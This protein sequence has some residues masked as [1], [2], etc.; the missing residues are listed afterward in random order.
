MTLLDN[1][2]AGSSTLTGR[3]YLRVSKD[4]F[5]RMRSPEQQHGEN[6][7]DAAA[8][9]IILGKPYTERDAVS[10]SRYSTK[11]RD[12][13]DQLLSDLA[14]GTFGA[15][16]LY[17]WE[18]SRGSRRVGEW[19][20]LLDLLEERGVK[21]RVKSHGRTYD[22][23][24]PRD[25]RTLLEDAVDSEYE[26]GKTSLR[27][28]RDVAAN[29][30]AG[31]PHGAAPYGYVAAHDERT[32]RLINWEPDPDRAPVIE[33][34]FERLRKGHSLK[35]IA[36][37]FAG[38]GIVNKRGRPFSPQHLRNLALKA[39][40]TGLRVHKGETVEGTWPKIVDRATWWEVQNVL[41]GVKHRTSASKPGRALHAFTGAVRCDVCGGP[42]GVTYTRGHDQY[43]CQT[44][45]CVRIAKDDVD[46]VLT[47][48]II[49]YLARPDVYAEL[50]MRPDRSER[51]A[52]LDGEI[53]ETRAKLSE[54]EDAEPADLHEARMCARVVKTLT[55]RLTEL[56]GR[57]RELA[58]P[59]VLA[60]LV[61]P[62]ADVAAR[63]NAAP[64]SAQR[65]AAE[66]LLSPRYLGEV[67]ITKSPVPNQR[68]DAVQRIKWR[69]S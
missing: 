51:L 59:P 67:R 52:E 6:E 31:R 8:N 41:S 44:S 25:R 23:A 30:A 37:D 20:T 2:L 27:I 65:K 19:V 45:G 17:L 61:E 63:W 69:R 1:P 15:D 64:I 3:E 5:G 36:R 7:D 13:F 49:G 16:I 43:R 24:N 35:L 62:G 54:A 42:I 29:A 38:R 12:G 57:R 39:S 21:V 18:S 55:E 26:S 4:R 46:E 56:E 50:A 58:T 32:G 9:G 14:A 66:M 11:K 47:A 60:A 28:R 22:P 33:E 40:Y 10:A 53:A 48:A 68:V 34:L